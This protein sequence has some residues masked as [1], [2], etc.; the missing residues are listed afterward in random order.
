[1]HDFDPGFGEQGL[2]WTIR[3]PDAAVDIRPGAGRASF[4]M[5]D[6]SITDYH[7]I[8]NGLFHFAPPDAGRVTFD[9]EWS[10]VQSRSKVRNADPNQHFGGE[11]VTTATHVSWKGWI[12]STLVFESDDNGQTTRFGQVGHEFNGAFFPG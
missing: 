9:V 6:L 3:I 10:G 12:G 1:M 4:R 8:P 7:S 11:L 2:F 5:A